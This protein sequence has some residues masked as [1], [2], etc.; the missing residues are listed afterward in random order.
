MINTNMS[1][2]L[3]NGGIQKSNLGQTQTSKDSQVGNAT[4]NDEIKVEISEHSSIMIKIDDFEKQLEK[5]FGEKKELNPE[6]LEIEKEIK[7]QIQQL[8]NNAQLP[9]SKADLE[10][11]EKIDTKIQEILT[12]SYSSYKDDEKLFDLTKQIDAIAKKYGPPALSQ[13]DNEKVEELENALHTLYGYKEPDVPLLIEAEKIY[14]QIDM[15]NLELKIK[16]LDENSDSYSTESTELFKKLSDSQ[17]S[18]KKLDNSKIRYETEEIRENAKNSIKNSLANIK[19]IRNGFS[20]ESE[21]SSLFNMEKYG[22]VNNDV[23]KEN[24]WLDF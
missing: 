10:S 24:K 11:I 14:T 18:L 15:L 19:A 17:N 13:N 6:E 22:L 21:T 1:A 4:D 3:Q 20:A 9:Y 8:N 5:I 7:L 2:Y 12:K 23:P 16:G